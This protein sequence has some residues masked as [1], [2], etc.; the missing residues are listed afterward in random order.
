MQRID[1]ATGADVSER[2]PSRSPRAVEDNWLF[3]SQDSGK[4]E[5]EV[6]DGHI[7]FHILDAGALQATPI[8]RP[9]VAHRSSLK[10]TNL[11]DFSECD[12]PGEELR[13]ISRFQMDTT[14]DSD[15]GADS[16]PQFGQLEQL[17]QRL[18]AANEEKRLE[19]ELLMARLEAE[20]RHRGQLQGDLA[21]AHMKLK[22]AHDAV[23][24][25]L[26]KDFD[27]H[28]HPEIHSD[29]SECEGEK[30]QS[31]DLDSDASTA[32]MSCNALHA[33]EQ[34]DL[35]K[36]RSPRIPSFI[37]SL[38]ADIQDI[39][40]Q[41]QRSLTDT[42]VNHLSELERVVDSVGHNL[43]VEQDLLR[44]RDCA[45]SVLP[46]VESI[47]SAAGAICCQVE[48]SQASENTSRGQVL[49]CEVCTEALKSMSRKYLHGCRMSKRFMLA[50][51]WVAFVFVRAAVRSHMVVRRQIENV[52]T[53]TCAQQV[54]FGQVQTWWCGCAGHTVIARAQ[55]LKHM[56]PRIW[57]RCVLITM[58]LICSRAST[59]FARGCGILRI[60]LKNIIRQFLG[61]LAR[62]V[63]LHGAATVNKKLD[64]S[65]APECCY[66]PRKVS[67]SA[68]YD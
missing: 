18:A 41:S 37:R 68:A 34:E 8:K 46:L 20:Q 17:R 23:E 55:T 56:G 51:Q 47:R 64:N 40:A 36:E 4:E 33:W 29:T 54:D 26:V 62:L 60:H 9:V 49:F 6:E 53:S 32:A 10:I 27:S 5:S 50:L 59:S 14:F 52:C 1:K 3:D 11:I 43:D 22:N 30:M 28:E 12:I 45:A 61:R 67:Q 66:C 39:C 58:A 2:V 42:I 38:D 57:S 13:P 24:S 63:A 35:S 16:E 31:A 48:H 19:V 15:G 65:T 25:L 44:L 7:S 21:E